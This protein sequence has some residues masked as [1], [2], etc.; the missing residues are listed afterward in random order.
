MKRR[1][2]LLVLSAAFLACG[3]PGWAQ[4]GSSRIQGTVHDASGA[5]VPGAKVLITNTGTG[6]VTRLT[7][8]GAGIYTTPALSFGN[9]KIDVDFKGFNPWEGSLLLRAGQTSVVDVTLSIAGV[10]EQV[11][12]AGDVTPLVNTTNQTVGNTLDRQRIADLPENGR[13][14]TNLVGITTPGVNGGYVNGMNTAAFEYIQD[15]AVLANE[16]FGG[17]NYKMPDPDSI[18]EVKVETSNSSAKFN[19]PASAILTTKAGTNQ[20]HG[21]VFETNR[22]NSFGIARK[23]E[24]PVGVKAPK[25]IRN[26]FGASVGG[27]IRIPH[28]YNGQDKSFFF[29]AYEGLELRNQTTKTYSVPT[30]A[31][32]GGDFSALTN[33]SGQ[34]LTLYDPLTTAASTSCVEPTATVDTNPY[35]RQPFANNQI[36][37]SRISP[38]AQ[39]IFAIMPHATVANVNPS[40]TTNWYGPAPNNDTE[41]TL[42]LRLDEHFN[43]KNNGYFR[44]THAHMAP[45]A[46]LTNNYGPPTT[47][48]SANLQYTPTYTDSGAFSFNHIFSSTFFSETVLSQEYESDLVEGGL[49]SNVD[50]SDQFGLPNPLG[51]PGFPVI[52]NI[53]FLPYGFG[54]GGVRQNSQE[55]T[56][57]DENLTLI[58]G[59]HTLQFGGRY[60]HDRIWVLPDANPPATNVS[61]SSALA[62]G[63]YN[64][65]S[66][67]A[68]SKYSTSG[69]S[70]ADF[71]LG[72][73]SSYSV[74]QNPQWYHFRGQ[75]ISGYFQ[76][77]FKVTPKLTLNLGIRWEIHPAFH[78][79]DGLFGGY[80]FKTGA[81]V[82]G[83]SLD[84]LYKLGRT[85]PGII[86]AL[87]ATGASFETA[88][89]AGLPPSLVYGNYHDIAP[90]FGAAYQLIS[91]NR[92]TVLR[93]GYGTYVYAP[94]VRN[95]YAETR[96]NPPF[97]ATYPLSYTDTTQDGSAN[98]L[99]RTVPTVVAGQNSSN[100]IDTTS[101]KAFPL[102]STSISSLDPHYPSTFVN[103]WNFTIE[104]G[105]LQSIVFR[106]SYIGVHGTNLEQYWDFD[107]PPGSYVWYVRTNSPTPT[108][109]RAPV[110]M[111]Q[112]PDLP[113]GYIEQQ[114][115]TGYSNDNSIQ[116]ELQRMHKNGYG[117]QVFYVLSNAFREGGN[118]WRDSYYENQSVFAPGAVPT[119]VN[120][121]NRYQNYF[122]DTTA[123]PQHQIRWNALMDL[124][125][126][127]GKR[128]LGNSNRWMDAL[129]GGWQ[130]SD[131]GALASQFWQPT[132]T[133]YQPTT[134]HLYKKHKISD[135]RS[136]KCKPGYLWYNGYI[137][138]DQVNQPNGVE[139]VPAGYTPYNTPFFP[140]PASGSV[141]CT[142]GTTTPPGCD[143]YHV[144]RE[145]NDVF[146]GGTPPPGAPLVYGPLNDGSSVVTSY[147]PGINPLLH[148]YQLGPFNWTMDASIF[149][150]FRITE[151]TA[152]QLNADFFNVLNEPGL[153][154]PDATIGIVDSTLS[155]NAP[156]QMQLTARFQF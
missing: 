128:F 78:E 85:N 25:L 76:D 109:P 24:D 120:A 97:T 51:M 152:L 44:F 121:S 134:M 118:G 29:V 137:R 79:H 34:P 133:L 32:R 155:N 13:S 42:T 49:H 132:T 145:T 55:I 138:A 50:F 110:A 21:S 36:P 156:R 10:N 153:K 14:V 43:E 114:R 82:T 122:R 112:Y 99:L 2:L 89:Q 142:S 151:R 5:I 100:L 68:L 136:G 93:G 91:G 101:P 45:Y 95:F 84:A 12:V 108:G 47:D 86:N 87:E 52:S 98:Y 56:N 71:F 129:V 41:R 6:T 53:G 88:Q 102:G 54:P 150:S 8:N 11:T 123:A 103:Q 27:P 127:R 135:C 28:L 116:L 64:P 57:L 70:A 149:K 148:R 117:F 18:Q 154:N 33:S 58:R 7:T 81:I 19:R 105:L 30:D 20:F 111:N 80:D 92:P 67:T 143:P 144:Y 37:S 60:R 139:G 4:S 141:A 65:A 35:C 94:P 119:D 131:V 17:A 130:I 15:G 147:A 26:E 74:V 3:V 73:A 39:K 1:F 115:K 66:K 63:M 48:G 90:R 31:M 104:Q 38:L 23:R 113:Y 59:R 140:T 83:Q 75:E 61:F 69:H 62:T 22:N 146:F 46:W 40:I 9:Y 106:A 16:D 126:G 96:A 107:T 72:Y 125:F 124:P 77:D